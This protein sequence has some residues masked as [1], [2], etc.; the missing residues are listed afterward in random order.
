VG[1][2][3]VTPSI[4]PLDLQEVKNHLRESG[5]DQDEL[6]QSLIDAAVEW[7]EEYTRR[8]F[9]NQTWDITYD[10]FPPW[11]GALLLPFAPLQSV[12]SITYTDTTGAPVVLS[13]S[14][15]TVDTTAL[16]PRIVPAFDELWPSTQGHINDVTVQAVFG[17]GSLPTDVP[18]TVRTRL[19]E[20]VHHLFEHRT[21]AFV[22]AARGVQFE[23]QTPALEAIL[24]PLRLRRAWL[25]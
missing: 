2:T 24:G 21:P 3:L 12:T 16:S 4:L 15:Y 19:L 8:K 11:R 5:T 18:S 20:A 25:A 10:R 7:A 13:S 23:Q 17:Y 9:I 14:L 22:G 6:I 1:E